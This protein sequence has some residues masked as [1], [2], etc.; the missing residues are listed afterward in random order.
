M[1][2]HSPVRM[3]GLSIKCQ[4]GRILFITGEEASGLSKRATDDMLLDLHAAHKAA[5]SE[6][7]K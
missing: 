1:G 4:C 3:T 2:D 7:G 6:Q 5:M